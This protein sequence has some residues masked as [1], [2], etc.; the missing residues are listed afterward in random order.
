MSGMY[1]RGAKYEF[2]TSS[3]KQY[4]RSSCYT[5]TTSSQS[6]LIKTSR[7]YD[8]ENTCYIKID[9]MYLSND[10]NFMYTTKLSNVDF[11][12]FSLDNPIFYYYNNYAGDAVTTTS[13]ASLFNITFSQWEEDGGYLKVTVKKKTSGG[14][15]L[16]Y[17]GMLKYNGKYVCLKNCTEYSRGSGIDTYTYINEVIMRLSDGATDN[18]VTY[19]M[20]TYIDGQQ[21]LADTFD[22]NINVG[23][24]IDLG[25]TTEN[26]YIFIG[27]G[28]QYS[29]A[30]Y[31]RTVTINGIDYS[32]AFITGNTSTEMQTGICSK[33]ITNS[34]VLKEE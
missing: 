3:C 1:Y 29:R 11:S 25:K 20:R 24:S 14:K 2:G 15:W 6:G 21:I 23:D 27:W 17:K 30:G 19:S 5:T 7:I 13:D 12:K 33:Q 34:Y 18:S 9:N 31:M 16:G 26:I 32:C 22:K 10:T 28:G 8:Y 4:A